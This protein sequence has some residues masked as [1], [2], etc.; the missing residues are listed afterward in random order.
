MYKNEKITGLIEMDETYFRLSNKGNRHLKQSR[1]HGYCPNLED[2]RGL[3]KD[4]ICISTAIDRRESVF[5]AFSGLGVP[6]S[7]RLTLCYDGHILDKNKSKIITDGCLAYVKFAKENNLCLKR[8]EKRI[9]NR[10]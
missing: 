9:E 2:S 10:N 6:S 3:S 5:V 8:L 1:H 4:K 7:E